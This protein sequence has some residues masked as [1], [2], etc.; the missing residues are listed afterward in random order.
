[1][2]SS[3][4]TAS[5]YVHDANNYIALCGNLLVVN[6]RRLEID[7]NLINNENVCVLPEK[8]RPKTN[9]NDVVWSYEGN[10]SVIT[11]SNNGNLMIRVN[12]GGKV[13]KS[14]T[15]YKCATYPLD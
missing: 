12:T 4:E 7:A 3:L 6:I 1:M 11:I 8:Y 10:Y 15:V 13:D 9:I 5:G 2:L 14:T